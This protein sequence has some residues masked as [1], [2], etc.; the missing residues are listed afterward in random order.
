MFF[1]KV[2]E[3]EDGHSHY[4]QQISHIFFR[5]VDPHWP[6]SP[7]FSWSKPSILAN[8]SLLLTKHKLSLIL[9]C[10][11]ITISLP[12]THPHTPVSVVRWKRCYLLLSTLLIYCGSSESSFA[13]HFSLH[14]AQDCSWGSHESVVSEVRALQGILRSEER[15]MKC[16]SM[17]KMPE[18]LARAAPDLLLSWPEETLTL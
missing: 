15:Q 8:I 5:S 10:W 16:F 11:T 13:R 18:V 2:A 3:K 6:H 7:L 4:Q 17:Q 14:G 9:K 1:T 12:H